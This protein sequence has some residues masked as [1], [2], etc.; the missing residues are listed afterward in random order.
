MRTA[1]ARALGSLGGTVTMGSRANEARNVVRS[2]LASLGD[3]ETAVRIEAANALAMIVWS[4]SAGTMDLLPVHAA[5]MEL[6]DAEVPEVRG[7]AIRAIG[8]VGPKISTD[9]PAVLIGAMEDES[10]QNRSDAIDALTSFT[11]VASIGP[12]RRCSGPRKAPARSFTN[13]TCGSW[14]E[15]GHPSSRRRPSPP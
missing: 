12:C 6:L 1:T 7:A 3:R 2:L 4:D 14:T 11:R 9:P 15:S 13:L 5:L 10:A 8:L